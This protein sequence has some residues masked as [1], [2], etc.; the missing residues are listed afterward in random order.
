MRLRTL[1]VALLIAL[2]LVLAGPNSVADADDAT[3]LIEEA[4]A[5]MPERHESST[6]AQIIDLY[7]D[8]LPQ[9]DG[10]NRER[11]AFVLNR[12]SRLHYEAAVLADG[13]H[14]QDRSQLNR[15]REFGFR[16]LRL[17]PDF[18]DW[19]ERDFPKALSFIDDR[20][21]LLWAGDAWGQM[22]QLN[23]L[24]GLTNIGSLLAMYRRCLEIE[25]DAIQGAGCHRSIGAMLVTTPGWLG[26]DKAEGTDHL[27]QAIE[28]APGYLQNHMVYAE[29]WGFSYDGFGNKNGIRDRAL[30]EARLQLVAEAPIGDWP[31]WNRIAKGQIERLRE[32][33]Q[34]FAAH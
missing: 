18:A 26:G 5:L 32:E 1:V 9:F 33:L 12:L 10:L 16:S 20:E 25:D 2:G 19:E 24:E 23:P 14:P 3:A 15:A 6:M 13:M 30:I 31:F 8:V 7:E 27:E 34:R 17:D 22:F 21:A 28:Q 29:Y 4:E 11:Q